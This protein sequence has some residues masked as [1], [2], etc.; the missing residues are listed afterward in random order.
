MPSF[1]VTLLHNSMQLGINM[2]DVLGQYRI[3][4]SNYITGISTPIQVVGLDGGVLSLALG[5]VRFLVL[6]CVIEKGF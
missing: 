4:S 2:A 3:G 1:S 5:P 6:P